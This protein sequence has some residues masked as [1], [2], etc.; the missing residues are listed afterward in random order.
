MGKYLDIARRLEEQM[1][2]SIGS[3]V[4][5]LEPATFQP[6]ASGGQLDFID[7]LTET[8][9][10]YYLNLLEIMQSEKFGMDRVTA[11]R[12]AGAI[13]TRNRQPLQIQQAAQDYRKNGYVQ[14]YSTV[15]G[16]AVYLARDETTAKRVPDQT[17]SVFLE[18][19]IEAVKGLTPDEAKVMLEAR[20][21]FNGPVKVE[22]YSEP[23]SPRMTDGKQIARNFYGKKGGAH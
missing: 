7:H 3:P 22:N 23:Q 9:R 6:V 12:E 14:I 10:E 4:E 17:I 2:G 19:D 15:L 1:V 16:E 21:I 18:S 20:I 5:N 11:E 13:I 8:E